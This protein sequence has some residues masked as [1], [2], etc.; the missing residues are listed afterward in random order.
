MGKILEEGDE[1]KIEVNDVYDLP[2]D[3]LEYLLLSVL[4]TFQL[5]KEKKSAVKVIKNYLPLLTAEEANALKKIK[6]IDT[7]VYFY[8]NYSMECWEIGKSLSEDKL[9]KI[10]D[11]T[12]FFARIELPEEMRKLVDE[13]IAKKKID[14]EKRSQKRKERDII[15]AKKL[16]EKYGLP[17]T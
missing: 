5:R 15:K 2:Q 14:L 17:V 3:M 8:H 6:I 16:L 10:T 13:Y 9:D 11:Q 1:P 7:N 12:T 4:N